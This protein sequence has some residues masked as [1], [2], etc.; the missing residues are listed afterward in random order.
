MELPHVSCKLGNKELHCLIDTGAQISLLNKDLVDKEIENLG[1][2]VPIKNTNLITANGKK[3]ITVNKIF[4][5]K[6]NIEGMSLDVE[7]VIIPNLNKNCILGIDFLNKYETIV[8]VGKKNLQIQNSIVSWLKDDQEDE[9]LINN[10]C[11]SDIEVQSNLNIDELKINCNTLYLDQI[12]SLLLE[13]INLI[14]DSPGL[15]KNYEHRLEVDESVVFKNKTYPIPAKYESA[16]FRELKKMIKDK[17]IK[18]S[19]S[20]FINPLVVVVKKNKRSTDEI[21]LRLCLDARQLNSHTKPQFE[22]P[23]NIS[24]LLV[25]CSNAKWFTKLDLKSSFWLVP[26]HKDSQKYCSFMVNGQ[27]FSFLVVP[28]GLSTSTAALVRAMQE[29][30]APLEHCV[31]H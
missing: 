17:I 13:N 3:I 10:Y 20:R 16:V 19:S 14:N 5:V 11:F 22:M 24:T 9:I 30:L 12:R 8:N 18:K 28:F 15:A 31:S 25:R 1:T 26:L 23:Q 21:K 29:I 2:F 7:F 27:I 6:I 4:C